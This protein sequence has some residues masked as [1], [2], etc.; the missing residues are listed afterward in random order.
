VGTGYDHLGPA[1]EF[2][3]NINGDVADLVFERD[4]SSKEHVA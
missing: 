2:G 4:F 1:G 3:G